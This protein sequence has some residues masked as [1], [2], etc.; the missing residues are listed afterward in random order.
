[1]F[2]CKTRWKT[3]FASIVLTATSANARA[4]DVTWGGVLV[5]PQTL[6]LPGVSVDLHTVDGDFVATTPTDRAGRFEFTVPAGTYQLTASLMGFATFSE[7][8]TVAQGSD[9]RIGLDIGSFTQE[10]V[11]SATMPELAMELVVPAIEAEQRAVRDVAEH[12]RT[13][14][15]LWAVR[16][17]PINLDPTIRGLQETQVAMFVDGTRTFAAGPARMDSDISHVSPHTLKEVRVVKG[18]YALT[19]GTGALSAVRVET[20]R[21]SFSGGD[22]VLGGRAGANYEQSGDAADGF[23]GLWGSTDRARFALYHNTRTANDYEDGDDNLIPGD[24]ES[25]DTRWA[26][27][28]KPNTATTIE[29]LGGYQEQ[30]NID[31]AGRILDASFFKTH[32]HAGEVTWRPRGSMVSEVYAQVYGNLKDHLMNNEEKPT[33]VDMPGRIPPF[34]LRVELPTTSDTIGGRFHVMLDRG[35]IGWKI[36]GDVTDLTQRA[37]RSIFRRSNDFQVFSDIVWPDAKLTNLGGYSQALFAWGA[38]QLGATVRIDALDA[39]A[40]MVSDFFAANTTGTLDQT[41]TNVSAAVNVTMPITDSFV[42][43][44]GAGRTVRSATPSE[45]YSDRFPSTKFQVAAEFMGNPALDPEEALELNAGGLFQVARTS[46]NADFFYRTI[47]RYI[48]VTPD[49]SLP[50]RLPLSPNTVYRYIN[51][52]EARFTGFEL[53]AE[54]GLGAHV[55]LS[56]AVSYVWAEDTLLDEPVFGIAPLEQRYAIQAHTADQQRWIELGVTVV[57]DQDRVATTRLERATQGWNV[58]DMR[59]AV[60]IGQGVSA[61]LGIENLTDETYATHLNSLNP[62]TGQ[63]VNETGRS[64]YLGLEYRF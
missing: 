35:A 5:D 26:A 27:G 16:R 45:R 30:R 28:F 42:F 29:Y 25:F 34:G 57:G 56:A 4:Q 6:P 13:E 41:E 8:M 11:V 2:R 32:S 64:F 54:S 50:R 7:Q 9:V 38:A 39:S 10:V 15:G 55:D 18:P 44:A 49:P 1:M 36:G 53:Q 20:F 58:V 51:G 33:A 3:V 59:A 21:P 46:V 62:F 24:Y 23:V 43:S 17:G 19:W 61:R 14:P 22:L 37:T 48:T 31:Y 47:D 12:L 40:D 60:A 63:R 52:A